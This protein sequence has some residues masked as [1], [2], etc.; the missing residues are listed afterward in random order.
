MLKNISKPK[1]KKLQDAIQ[2]KQTEVEIMQKKLS[3]D[4]FSEYLRKKL[5]ESQ[6]NQYNYNEYKIKQVIG[7]ISFYQFFFLAYYL[8]DN[9]MGLTT[10]TSLSELYTKRFAKGRYKNMGKGKSYTK[11]KRKKK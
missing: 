8:T 1:L 10:S 5:L 4:R 11:K 9:I 3:K 6:T 7:E 2:T